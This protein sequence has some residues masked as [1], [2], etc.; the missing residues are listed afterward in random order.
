[1]QKGLY[2]FSDGDTLGPLSEKWCQI[3]MKLHQNAGINSNK[4]SSI[5]PQLC[6]GVKQMMVDYQ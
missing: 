1:M 4:I 6:R 2:K 5:T 3:N